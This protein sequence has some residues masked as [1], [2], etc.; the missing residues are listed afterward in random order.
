MECS[1]AIRLHQAKWHPLSF[2]TGQKRIV[3][4]VHDECSCMKPALAPK[5][6]RQG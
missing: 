5:A 3:H 2:L 1:A 6:G 4:I